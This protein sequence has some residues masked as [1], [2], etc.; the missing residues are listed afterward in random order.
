[1]LCLALWLLNNSPAHART[2]LEQAKLQQDEILELLSLHR[3]IAAEYPA[4]IEN[5]KNQKTV[6]V[7]Y[8]QALGAEHP[9]DGQGAQC[10]RHALHAERGLA[11][12]ACAALGQCQASSR[13]TILIEGS[14]SL[15]QG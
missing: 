1:M 7:I 3:H 12:A 14:G 9:R 8:E 2:M 15:I 10:S 5:Q 13:S 6:L 11:C 4:A